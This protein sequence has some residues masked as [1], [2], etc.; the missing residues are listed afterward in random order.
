M[1]GVQVGYTVAN[2]SANVIR[3]SMAEL[4]IYHFDFFDSKH[5]F[6]KIREIFLKINELFSIFSE[7]F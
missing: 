1:T 6:S 2:N 5:I 4:F 3:I 7:L